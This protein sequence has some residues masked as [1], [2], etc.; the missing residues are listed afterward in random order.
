MHDIG[1]SGLVHCDDPEG[2]DGEGVGKGV[3]DGEY[4]YTH[5]GFKSKYGK[6]QY[7]IVKENE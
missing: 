5:G 4:T 7:N 6:K 1:C 3:Q 2:W